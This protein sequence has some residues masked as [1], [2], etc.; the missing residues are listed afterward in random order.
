MKAD[1]HEFE[2]LNSPAY[3]ARGKSVILLVKLYFD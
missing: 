3:I 2:G 1:K